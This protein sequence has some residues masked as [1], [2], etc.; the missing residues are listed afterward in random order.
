MAPKPTPRP[1]RKKRRALQEEE[2][3]RRIT[4]AAVKLHGTLGPAG[5]GVT[6]IAKLAG[7]SRMTVYNHF[8][9]EA[10]LLMACSTHWAA[11]N[12]FPALSEWAVIDDPAERLGTALRELYRWYGLTEGMLGKVLR[13]APVV[14]AVASVLDDLWWPYLRAVVDTLALGWPRKRARGDELTAALRL[15]VDFDTWRLLTGSGLDDDRAADLAARMVIA[16]F[17]R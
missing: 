8:P 7:V 16:P 3:R 10:D 6:D 15:A 17:S 5:S 9:T 4:K 12:P 2:T 14:A 13:D 11:K 1:Y